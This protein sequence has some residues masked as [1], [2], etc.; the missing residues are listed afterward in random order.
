VS[1]ILESIASHLAVVENIKQLEP[2]I[3]K[4]V[5]RM[6]SA[7]SKGGKILLMGNGGSAA[8]AQHIAAELVVRYKINRKAIPALSLTTDPSVV[9]A[10]GN[11]LGFA[12]L[13]ARQVE[14]HARKGD[15]VIGL[16]TSGTS[17]N[18][19]KAF[20]T[21]KSIGCETIAFL[22]NDGGTIKSI[23]DIPLI[24]NSSDTPRIQEC[25]I[26]IGHIIC[27]LVEKGVVN[28]AH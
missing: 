16:S 24:V 14:A 17:E 22:G 25:H 23:V 10:M 21:A 5:D 19:Y 26:L 7:I 3:K 8:D 12:L 20:E 13:F 27:D 15:I 9:T 28:N 2:V 6:V 11:D 1:F 4:I 18:V